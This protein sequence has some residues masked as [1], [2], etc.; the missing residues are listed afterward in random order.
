MTALDHREPDR[1]PMELGSS[2]GSAVTQGFYHRLKAH[3]DIEA[4]DGI[5]G[6]WK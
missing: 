1:V 4:E 5:N 6:V 2:E 3:F